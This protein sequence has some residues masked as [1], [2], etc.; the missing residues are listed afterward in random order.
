MSDT[1]PP[2]NASPV[3]PVLPGALSSGD[4]TLAAFVKSLDE[5]GREGLRLIVLDSGGDAANTSGADSANGVANTNSMAGVSGAGS[6]SVAADTGG[7]FAAWAKKNNILPEFLTDRINE[8]F[9]E[10]SGDLLIETYNE[11]PRIQPEY[12]VELYGLFLPKH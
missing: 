7:G 8:A 2:S 3:V 12:R 11:E 5:T 10:F 9:R 6:A 4:G 1:F